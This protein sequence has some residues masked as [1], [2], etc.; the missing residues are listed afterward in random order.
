[1]TEFT[2]DG[3]RVYCAW[4]ALCMNQATTTEP[5]PVLGD[6]PICD[7]CKAKVRAMS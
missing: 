6:V 7:R 5:H 1:M 3:K 4:F 2:I